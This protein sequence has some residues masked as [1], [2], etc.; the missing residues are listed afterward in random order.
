VTVRG[1]RSGGEAV[2]LEAKPTA[3]MRATISHGPTLAAVGS[4]APGA[5]SAEYAVR[6]Y[7]VPEE[8]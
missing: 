3:G 2:A 4:A 5:R 7:E 8:G 1:G 6:V